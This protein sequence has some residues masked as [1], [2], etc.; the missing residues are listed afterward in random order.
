VQ[1]ALG[2]GPRG[3]GS[4]KDQKKRPRRRGWGDE[5]TPQK[6]NTGGRT[7]HSRGIRRCRPSSVLAS[8]EHRVRGQKTGGDG[9]SLPAEVGASPVRSVSAL[10]VKVPSTICTH[11]RQKGDPDSDVAFRVTR[12]SMWSTRVATLMYTVSLL[13]DMPAHATPPAINP[14]CLPW[15][16]PR[17]CVHAHARARSR[18]P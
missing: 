12:I 15:K 3:K 10:C 2:L 14:L 4:P 5:V 13:R 17:K 16:A 1:Q 8:G 7:G 6:D 11:F 18:H 9:T